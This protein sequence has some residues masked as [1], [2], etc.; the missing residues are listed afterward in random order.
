MQWWNELDFIWKEELISILL[1][2]PGYAGKGMEQTN[3]LILADESDQIIN[4]I[5]NLEKVHISS[6]VLFNLTP[7]FY[8]K[9]INN[10]HIQEPEYDSNDFQFLKLYPEHLRSKVYALY[11]DYILMTDLT[12]LEDFVNLEVIQCQGCQLESLDGIEK[13]RKLKKFTADQGNFF[14][15]LKPLQ[16]LGLLDLDINFSHVTDISPL[17]EIPTLEILDLSFTKVIDLTPLSRLS[18]LK[19]VILPDIREVKNK[20]LE[21]YLWENYPVDAN[22]P[23]DVH[24]ELSG[25]QLVELYFGKYNEMF[26]AVVYSEKVISEND[27]FNDVKHAYTFLMQGNAYV[28]N[29]FFLGKDI[30]Q[31]LIHNAG[32]QIATRNLFIMKWNPDGIDTK[33]IL[34]YENERWLNENIHR[35]NFATEKIDAFQIM[36]VDETHHLNS[37]SSFFKPNKPASEFQ[38]ECHLFISSKNVHS[39][40]NLSE[41]HDEFELHLIFGGFELFPHIQCPVGKDEIEQL[42]FNDK[43]PISRS[44]GDPESNNNKDNHIFP[45][46][47]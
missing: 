15:D 29:P 4:D 36:T 28:E 46:L 7:L 12:P 18:N 32:F 40:D 20:E 25:F 19:C 2:S 45:N 11:L 13:L 41:F 47:F 16:G 17:A 35:T 27:L 23:M 5:V 43:K 30:Y 24:E 33:F 38:K 42:F 14:T 10:F 44:E 9:R 1:E 34:T 3:A 31:Y 8:L 26:L 6:K 37:Y 21:Q 22:G 39:I